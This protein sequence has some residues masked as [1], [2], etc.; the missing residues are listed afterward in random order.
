MKIILRK[1]REKSTWLGIVTL[2]TAVGVPIPPEVAPVV[3]ELVQA[4]AGIA[5]VVITP[6]VV[7]SK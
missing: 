3:G 5:L 6:R 2:L 4:V 7:S 1:L